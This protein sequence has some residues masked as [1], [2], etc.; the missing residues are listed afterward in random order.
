MLN[1]CD[2]TIWPGIN[3]TYDPKPLL[4]VT[5]AIPTGF[6]LGK[7]EWKVITTPDDWAG[8][9]WGRT[10]CT[11]DSTGGFSC[12]TG[13]C[14]SGQIECATAPNG[15][16]PVTMAEFKMNN[17]GHD[18][19]NVSLLDGYNLPLLV[20]P[21]NQSCE[22]AGCVV[23]LNGVCPPE[24]EVDSSDGKIVGCKSACDAFATQPYCCDGPIETSSTC[25][26][27]SYSQ[28]FKK[29]VSEHLHL[30]F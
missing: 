17:P 4:Y 25:K 27:T 7:N 10:Q 12:I 18:F 14:G 13:D 26:P 22:N 3:S 5:P 20:L 11:E 29:K 23:D 19:F 15:S 16:I 6:S 21:S 28:N 1:N 30:S 2:Y 8:R 9:L 24:L